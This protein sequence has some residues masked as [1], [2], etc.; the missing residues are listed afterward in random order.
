M[1]PD[2][3]YG[4]QPSPLR[5]LI[6]KIYY[7]KLT[8]KIREKVL[9]LTYLVDKN[10]HLGVVGAVGILGLHPTTH[11]KHHHAMELPQLVFFKFEFGLPEKHPVW[12]QDFANSYPSPT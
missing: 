5:P 7:N 8:Q 12:L 9:L 3:P 6:I 10:H 11:F 2:W 1:R 4:P